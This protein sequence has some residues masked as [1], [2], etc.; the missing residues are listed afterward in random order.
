[1]HCPIV[2]EDGP[3]PYDAP[4]DQEDVSGLITDSGAFLFVV[5]HTVEAEGWD[6]AQIKDMP[7]VKAMIADGFANGRHAGATGR[8][9][10]AF[11]EEQEAA[12]DDDAIADT[13]SFDSQV[14]A[15]AVADEMD[16]APRTTSGVMSRFTRF[17]AIVLA[18]Q[19]V[20][21][22]WEV[23][24]RSNEAPQIECLD[25]SMLA[26]RAALAMPTNAKA[27]CPP[28]TPR[29]GT[30]TD[31]VLQ[32][33][34]TPAGADVADIAEATGWGTNTVRGFLAA[35]KKKGVAYVGTKEDRGNIRSTVY[36]IPTENA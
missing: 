25:A 18:A 33:L 35:M 4:A 7:E 32:L 3:A 31:I 15:A 30:K 29:A 17:G 9:I 22:V 27:T 26:L 11:L 1:V 20:L 34:R 28:K 12:S 21:N 6:F 24:Y 36:R 8:D 2:L 5:T 16:A 23:E 19:A 10:I 13:S 14:E